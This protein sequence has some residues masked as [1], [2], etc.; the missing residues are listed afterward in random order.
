MQHSSIL[1][2]AIAATTAL[3]APSAFDNKLEV[4]LSGPQVSS[5]K[6]TFPEFSRA[7]QNPSNTGPFNF[8]ELRVGAAIRN[9]KSRC[10]ILDHAGKPIVVKRGNNIDITFGD[11][12]KGKWTFRDQPSKVSKVICDPAFKQSDASGN[13]IRVQLSNQGIEL[14]I[15]VALPAGQRQE[16]AVSNGPFE[17]VEVMVGA[18]VQKQDYRCQVLDKGG[19]PIV[20]TRG[21]NRDI[22]FSDADKG[23]WKFE[24][25]SQV[26]K[27]ICDPAFKAGSA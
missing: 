24:R 21:T 18:L 2:A 12:G 13:E 17:T 10:Q 5:A 19:K 20:A 4:T 16:K 23:E 25:V 9:P 27:V 1:L 11:G 22:T 7:A 26:S 6:N 15:Q 14:G 8:V 3:A